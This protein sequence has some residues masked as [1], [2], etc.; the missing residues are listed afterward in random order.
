V[1]AAALRAITAGRLYLAGTIPNL[2]EAAESCGSNVQYVRAAIVVLK[3]ENSTLLEHVLRGHFP[4]LAAASQVE[5]L[6][7][8]LPRGGHEG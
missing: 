6:W 3:S 4:L 5:R 7:S 1:R 2:L 8:R